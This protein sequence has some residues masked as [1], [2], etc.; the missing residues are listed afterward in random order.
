MRLKRALRSCERAGG[1]SKGIFHRRERKKLQAKINKKK[2]SLDKA[3]AQLEDI[4]MLHGYKMR[5]FWSL[6]ISIKSRS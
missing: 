3:T 6:Y 4:P 2:I 1:Y 5:K